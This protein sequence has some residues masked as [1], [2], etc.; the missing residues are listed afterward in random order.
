MAQSEAAARH[1][2][3]VGALSP[4][5]APGGA[6]ATLD[7]AEAQAGILSSETLAWK[8]LTY[9]GRTFEFNREVR[10]RVLEEDGGWAFES[11]DPRIMGFGH[12]RGEAESSFCFGFAFNWDQIACEDDGN[13]TLDARE[14][15]RDL[16]ALVRAQK[17]R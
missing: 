10:I 1:G 14:V 17:Q 12:T 5:F 15:K 8:E 9:R 16:L 3:A 6:T 4:V 13:L 7:G 2:S 11:D